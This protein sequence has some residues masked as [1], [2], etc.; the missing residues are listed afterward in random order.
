MDMF[1]YPHPESLALSFGDESNPTCADRARCIRA[2]GSAP[3]IFLTHATYSHNYAFSLARRLDTDSPI[4]LLPAESGNKFSRTI[5]GMATRMVRMIQA[6]Q[7]VGP[8]RVAGHS[9]GG[10][11]AYE[12]AAQL[13]GANQEVTFVGLLGT[14]YQPGVGCTEPQHFDDRKNLLDL[15]AE[16]SNQGQLHL[17]TTEVQSSPNIGFTELVKMYQEQS[18]LPNPY[19]RMAAPQIREMLIRE[20]HYFFALRQYS[21]QPIQLPIHC[22]MVQRE[23]EA[24][25]STGWETVV[26]ESQIRILPVPGTHESMVE[27]PHVAI[28]AQA[29]SNVIRQSSS[30]SRQPRDENCSPLIKLQIGR[31]QAP[32]LLCIPGAGANV[33][34][35]MELVAHLDNSL[36]IYGLQPR[37]QDGLLPPHATVS[38][39]VGYYLRAIDQIDSRV[40]LNL[41]GHSFG[42]WAAF[43]LAQTLLDIGRNVES[44]TIVDSAAPDNHD[45]VSREY[46]MTDISMKW[47]ELLELMLERQLTVHRSD[48]NSLDEH[49]QRR[50]LH[51]ILLRES[52]LPNTSQPDILRGPLRTC[53]AALRTSFTPDRIYAGPARLVL[54]DHPKLSRH[55]NQLKH[56][57]IVET[58]KKWIPKL[59]V[60]HAPGNHLTLLKSPNV[61]KLAS[62]LQPRM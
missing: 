28:L 54:V 29:F 2:G 4:Y 48:F 3:P 45:A 26:P 25:A 50:F 7:P 5:E 40:Q 44:L 1:T 61:Q 17:T 33:T 21:A 52:I 9:F 56:K 20:R 34:S 27:D 42:G 38:S 43:E 23:G 8:Y 59:S 60:T 22:F 13:L 10:V 53:A 18:M 46:T 41:L 47:I 14:S 51:K 49:G 37:G 16:R 58:W 15:I 24:V 31:H 11:L 30:N 57:E 39:A 19:D 12:I 36:Q 62:L 32:A 6:I 55:A 35:F